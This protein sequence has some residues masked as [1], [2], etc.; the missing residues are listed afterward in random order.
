MQQG[1]PREKLIIGLGLYGRSF[2]LASASSYGVGASAPQGG[3]AGTFTRESGFL[4]YYEV[5]KRE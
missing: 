4:S 2:T 3:I 1:A 5:R